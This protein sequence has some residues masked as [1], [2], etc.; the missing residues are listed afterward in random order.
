MW[1]TF[2]KIQSI[3]PQKTLV[4]GEFGAASTISIPDTVGGIEIIPEDAVNT[5]RFANLSVENKAD[6]NGDP[7][8]IY[9]GIGITPTPLLY[10]FELLSGQQEYAM[11]IG[12]QAIEAITE[13]GQAIKVNIQL[14]NAVSKLL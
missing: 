11:Q 14:A 4:P 7:I 12:S 3:Q 13:S 2:S 1:T 5:V 9:V 6:T 8:S 10:S